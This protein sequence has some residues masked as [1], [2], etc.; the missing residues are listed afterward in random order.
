MAKW[1]LN[2]GEHMIEMFE[3]CVNCGM[4]PTDPLLRQDPGK[5]QYD[6]EQ[7]RD[8]FALMMKNRQDAASGLQRD[9]LH[10]VPMLYGDNVYSDGVIAETHREEIKARNGGGLPPGVAPTARVR[11][12]FERLLVA[13]FI[14]YWLF[15]WL[16]F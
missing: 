8:Q 10:K 5:A 6:R 14:G 4:R 11:L 16:G 9:L 12:P 1:C 7:G 3:P 15:R 2:C 13:L